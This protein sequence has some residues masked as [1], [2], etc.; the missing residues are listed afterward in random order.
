LVISCSNLPQAGLQMNSPS[1]RRLAALCP[2]EGY[3]RCHVATLTSASPDAPISAAMHA[4][5]AA[6][7]TPGSLQDLACHLRRLV[8]RVQVPRETARDLAIHVACELLQQ[9]VRGAPVIGPNGALIERTELDR[10]YN[11]GD[12]SGIRRAAGSPR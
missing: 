8:R 9:I 7:H 2:V 3:D 12:L 11:E 4:A 1:G 5:P 10:N 6:L